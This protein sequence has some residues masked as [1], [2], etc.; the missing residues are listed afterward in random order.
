MP[1][2]TLI[3]DIPKPPSFRFR[4]VSPSEAA[5]HELWW[6]FNQAEIDM[7]HRSALHGLIAGVA[8]GSLTEV[9]R[10]AEA[11]HAARKI[12]DR[13]ERMR[14]TDALLLAG[15]YTERPWSDAVLK[16]LPGGLA[17][18][19]QASVT[20]RAEFE[21][22]R[23]RC[24]TRAKSVVEFI[25]EVVRRGRADL[26]AEWRKELEVACAIAVHAYDR[27]RGAGPSVVPDEDM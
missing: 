2:D 13:L 21:C 3:L 11:T 19:A 8:P 4:D 7:E 15:L 14:A 17:G 1:M 5:N 12:Q 10:C 18:A 27:V 25:E 9:E 22:A 6:F 20:A 26:V 23:A 16:A 24:L